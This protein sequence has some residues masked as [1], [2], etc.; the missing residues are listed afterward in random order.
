MAA[1]GDPKLER[2]PVPQPIRVALI[3]DD[4][5]TRH[6]WEAL[7]GNTPGFECVGGFGSIEE[8]LSRRSSWASAD[9][10]LLDIGLP[11]MSGSEAV[12]ELVEERPQRAVVMLTVHDD[13]RRIFESIVRGARGY[14]L[15]STRP[16]RL[17]EALREACSG[18][19]PMSPSVADKA[20]TLFRRY[21]P[22]PE[23]PERLSPRETEIL[24]LLAQGFSYARAAE[25]LDIS[26]NTVR[27]HIRSIYEKLHAH[28]KSEAVV[29]ALRANLL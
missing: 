20:L 16:A 3:D 11:G 12:G 9:V 22:P 21:A 2:G 15:K 1:R 24:G 4:L 5:R 27:D 19:A 26:I 8:A 6:A 13:E 17:L 7:I 28:S 14:L 29:K 23:R 18:G 10:V 25:R